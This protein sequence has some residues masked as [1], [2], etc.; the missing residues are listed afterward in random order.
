MMESKY[1]EIK[2]ATDSQIKWHQK[3]NL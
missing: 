1:K 3:N 2:E